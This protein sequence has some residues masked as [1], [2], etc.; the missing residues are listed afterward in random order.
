MIFH[1]QVPLQEV[2]IIFASACGVSENESLE[3]S[4]NPLVYHDH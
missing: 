4:Q 2:F 1:S 3:I